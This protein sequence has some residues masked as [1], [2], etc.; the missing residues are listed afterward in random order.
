MEM[1]DKEE[2]KRGG[3][4]VAEHDRAREF[5]PWTLKNNV[6]IT[7]GRAMHRWRLPSMSARHTQNDLETISR[8][9]GSVEQASSRATDRASRGTRPL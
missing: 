1:I 9:V 5:F 4:G 3:K 8:S 6:C 2:D 7:R